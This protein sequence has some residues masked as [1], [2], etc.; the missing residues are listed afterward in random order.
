MYGTTE[1]SLVQEISDNAESNIGNAITDS[2]AEYY[3][4]TEIALLNN[5]GIRNNFAT[6]NITGEDIFMVLPYENKIDRLRLKG[7]ELKKALELKAEN[8]EA[9]NPEKLPGFGMQVKILSISLIQFF[10]TTSARSICL[11]VLLLLCSGTHLSHITIKFVE[12]WI[13]MF[14]WHLSLSV[15][16]FM[17]TKRG[18]VVF[19]K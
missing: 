8:L 13:G 16:L 6:G 18:C 9:G 17:T 14:Y 5:G 2:M 11:S 4:D 7:G 12:E 15:N 1:T 10:I 19:I 3:D